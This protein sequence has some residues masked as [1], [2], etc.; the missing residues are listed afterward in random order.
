MRGW[1]IA[2]LKV[3][4]TIGE[5]ELN[6]ILG[7]E[8]Y[9]DMSKGS[10]CDHINKLK[11]RIAIGSYKNM[12]STWKTSFFTRIKQTLKHEIFLMKR[13]FKWVSYEC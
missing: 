4:I 5:N 1:K 7:L 6:S 11:A 12:L 9:K 3:E 10:D 13:A 2:C 8:A